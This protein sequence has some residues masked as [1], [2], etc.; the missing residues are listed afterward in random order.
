MATAPKKNDKKSSDL[1]YGEGQREQY[2]EGYRNRPEEVNEGADAS[3][4]GGWAGGERDEKKRVKTDRAPGGNP[5][6]SK[7]S[8]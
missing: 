2:G 6:E 3:T 5:D 7:P 8:P 1:K 4:D